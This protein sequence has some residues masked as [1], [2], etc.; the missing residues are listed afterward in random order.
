MTDPHPGTDRAGEIERL[1]ISLAVESARTREVNTET[2]AFIAALD[3]ITA[4]A[5]ECER[6]RAIAPR[7]AAIKDRLGV[8]SLSEVGT[9]GLEE[10]DE[11]LEAIFGAIAPAPPAATSEEGMT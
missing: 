1:V 6:M 3:A 7:I 2:P 5:A 10:I 8:L 4:L 11:H 9:D